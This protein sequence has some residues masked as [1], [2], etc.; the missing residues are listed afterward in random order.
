[1]RRLNWLWSLLFGAAAVATF[2]MTLAF[3]LAQAQQ[4]AAPQSDEAAKSPEFEVA[5][6]KPS[7]PG[8]DGST[9]AFAPGE[10]LK[11]TNGT[12]KG[13]IEMAYNVRDFQIAGGPGWIGSQQFDI[14]AKSAESDAGSQAGNSTVSVDE[15]RVRLRALLALRFE[16][17]VHT[18]TKELP[19]YILAVGKNGSKLA[20]PGDENAEASSP[21]GINARCGEMIGTST[22]MTNLA[23]KL[24]VQLDRPVV[25]QTGLMG[26]YNFQLSWSPEA[27]PCSTQTHIDNSDVGARAADGP[28]LFTAIQEQ[29]G[30]KLESQKGPVEVLVVD[31]VEQ[32]SEN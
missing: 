6:I 27:G 21:A 29:L 8:A 2:A 30:L 4:S 26:K 9:Y 17:K 7:R 10:G 31:L 12:L 15:T 5:T 20:E 16:L 18:E 25:D 11:V 24:S 3:G 14:V 23:Y 22:T 1:M 28:S 13:M 32:P 19:I